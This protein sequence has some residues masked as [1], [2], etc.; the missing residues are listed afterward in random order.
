MY[1][2]PAWMFDSATWMLPT[3]R[4]EPFAGMTARILVE[5][6]FLIAGRPGCPCGCACWFP[7]RCFESSYCR[8]GWLARQ[9]EH[10]IDLPPLSDFL[11]FF[12]VDRNKDRNREKIR[13][14]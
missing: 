14:L 6:R 4:D 13:L 3:P 1:L 2:V 9:G 12:G 8:H 10:A 5:L 7:L 11:A